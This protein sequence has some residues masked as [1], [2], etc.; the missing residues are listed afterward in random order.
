MG[1]PISVKILKLRQFLISTYVEK[2]AIAWAVW[3][4]TGIYKWET[5]PGL[6]S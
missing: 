1:S 4:G 5:S 3:A 6:G 2:Q